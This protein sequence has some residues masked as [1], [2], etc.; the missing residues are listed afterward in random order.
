[1]AVRL[2]ADNAGDVRLDASSLVID[3]GAGAMSRSVLL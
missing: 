1:M 2:P 3:S